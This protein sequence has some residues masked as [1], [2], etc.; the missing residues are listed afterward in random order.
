M[1]DYFTHL[2]AASKIFDKLDDD[3]KNSIKNRDLYLLGAQGGD[4]FFMYNLKTSQKN[5]GRRLHNTSALETF[6]RLSLGNMCYAA[7]YATHY[8]LDST[9]HPM[10]YA[11]IEGKKSP[12]STRNSRRTWGCT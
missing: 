3:T 7:G 12:S 11:Y 6:R 5:L 2:I 10:I 1:P 9:V 8:A 4:V